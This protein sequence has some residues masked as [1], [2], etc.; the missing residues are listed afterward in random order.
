[1]TKVQQIND[2]D[3]N[4]FLIYLVGTLNYSFE[5]SESYGNDIATFLLFLKEIDCSKDKVTNEIIRTYLL[6][7]NVRGLEKIS[8]RRM[9]SAL[10]HFYNFLYRF[11]GYDDNPF[12]TTVSPKVSKKLPEFLN[13]EEMN[14]FLDLNLKRDDDLAI[15]DQAIL[16]L[17][18]ASGLRASEVINLKIKDIDFDNR[19]LKV[20][21]KGKKERIVPFSNTAKEAV[22]KYINEYRFKLVGDKDDNGYLYLNK[23]GEQL[24]ERG[25]EHIVSFSA[26]KSGFNLKVYPHM[27][28]HSFAT[29]LLNNG[30]DLRVIQE[31]M[32]HTSISTTSIYTHVSYADL[33]KTYDECFPKAK[34]H[35]FK[36]SLDKKYVIFDFNGTMFFDSDKHVEAWLRFS[37]KYGLNITKDYVENSL[38]GRSNEDILPELFKR[39]FTKEEI[40]LYAE[41]KELCYRNACADDKENLHLAPGLI[42]F[43]DLLKANGIKMAIATG[44]PKSNVDW[45]FRIFY[46]DKWFKKEDVIYAGDVKEGKPKPDIYLKAMEHIGATP[47]KT[48]IFEDTMVGVISAF[49]AKAKYIVAVENDKQRFDEFLK[50]D[51]VNKVIENFSD[52]S[53]E[54]L[55][56]IGI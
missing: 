46:L 13:E 6:E 9:I 26:L 55:D 43:L 23:R 41:E 50:C 21:G 11:K 56:F 28:R 32:G 5:T 2:I 48:I 34:T 22:I 39:P 42:K 52:M 7:L 29:T 8:I 38:N 33:K 25:L 47:E 31:L 27:I 17:M 49:D 51:K 10:R 3:L 18:Y 45:Y 1:M 53:Q 24:T 16:E 37:K 54:I 36:K 40:N 20:F 30:V 19:L 35:L 4:D 12:E 14:R 44:S 15:R